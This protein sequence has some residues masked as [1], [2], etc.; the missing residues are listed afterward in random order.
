MH[1]TDTYE[2]RAERQRAERHAQQTAICALAAGIAAELGDGWQVKQP[3]PDRDFETVH[4]HIYRT[5]DGANFW[6]AHGWR[7]KDRI[8]VNPSWPLDATGREDRPHFSQYS[9]NGAAAPAIG[10]HKDKTAAQAARD[11]ARR[12]LPAFLPLW[13]KQLAA[14]HEDTERRVQKRQLATQIAELLA[15]EVSGPRDQHDTAE[16]GVRLGYRQRGIVAVNF[17]HDARSITVEV[18][19][20]FEELKRLAALFPQVEEDTNGD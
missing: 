18:R 15:A 1:D 11:I 19:C 3:D 12:F 9:E 8:A 20:T 16:Y 5:S 10:F 4:P 14:V 17:D 6:L 2:Q 7:D 13:E